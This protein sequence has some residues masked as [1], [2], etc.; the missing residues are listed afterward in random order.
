MPNK[1]DAT[2]FKMVCLLQVALHRPVFT[3]RRSL[4]DILVHGPEDE[5]RAMLRNI[6]KYLPTL[7]ALYIPAD[8]IIKNQHFHRTLRFSPSV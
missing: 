2:K 8:S 4:E 6:E 7:P 3:S 1:S 5:R